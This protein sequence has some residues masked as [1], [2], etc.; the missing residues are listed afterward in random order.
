MMCNWN[1][2]SSC[3]RMLWTISVLFSSTPSGQGMLFFQAPQTPIW[4]IQNFGTWHGFQ[5]QKQIDL[6]V[7]G[8]FFL[9]FRA[10]W[11]IFFDTFL[12]RGFTYSCCFWWYRHLESGVL[13]SWGVVAGQARGSS[14]NLNFSQACP[15]LLVVCLFLAVWWGS[16]KNVNIIPPPS[17]HESYLLIYNRE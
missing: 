4:Q 12:A 8:D 16:G 14:G 13:G 11:S 2:K 10:I 15:N 6:L 17:D 9:T 5:T 1:S 7:C 3:S